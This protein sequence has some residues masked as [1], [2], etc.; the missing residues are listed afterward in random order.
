VD[1]SYFLVQIDL[2]CSIEF[3]TD[4]VLLCSMQSVEL[5]EKA[6][7]FLKRLFSAFDSD[8]VRIDKS[9]VCALEVYSLLR[10]LKSN[11]LTISISAVF[12]RDVCISLT[13]SYIQP[14]WTQGFNQMSSRLNYSERIETVEI[15]GFCTATPG[16]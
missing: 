10:C 7:D 9:T 16:P 5:T 14:S 13:L 12:V 6:L 15:A 11:T 1:L 3:A 8:G 4:A 2:F